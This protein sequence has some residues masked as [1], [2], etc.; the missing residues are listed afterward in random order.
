[1]L[2]ASTLVGHLFSNRKGQTMWERTRRACALALAL[3]GLAAAS[4]A[5]SLAVPYSEVG[6]G[7]CYTG[8]FDMYPPRVIRPVHYTTF[9]NPERVEWSPDLYRWN[10]NRRK[11]QLYWRK[12]WYYAFTSSYGYFQ[13]ALTVP[14]H[15]SN[16]SYINFV[17]YQ[18][19]RRGWYATKNYIYWQALGRTIYKWTPRSCHVG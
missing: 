2:G 6:V 14:W 12:P 18:G 8:R 17:T 1:M 16:G 9:R 5:Q 7:Y 19:I 11:W 4:P 13:T 3:A 15:A 10:A